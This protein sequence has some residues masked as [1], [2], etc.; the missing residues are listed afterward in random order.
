MT[1][2]LPAEPAPPV[3]CRLVVLRAEHD[4]LL[5]LLE[6]EGRDLPVAVPIDARTAHALRHVHALHA[7]PAHCAQ[8]RPIH[9]DLLL[10]AVRACGAWPLCVV[11]RPGPD[12]A[13]WL[14][15]VRDGEPVEVDL[16]VLDAVVLLLADRLPVT[17]TDV[18]H[19]PWQHTIDRLLTDRPA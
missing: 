19:D 10:R 14:R 4:K 8:R 1:P 17:V 12:P 7:R 9:V 15:I 16:D 2:R 3:G 18:D 11:V 5:V 6:V 13:F